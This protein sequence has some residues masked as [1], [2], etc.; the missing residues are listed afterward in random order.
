MLVM[1]DL[2]G[3]D[4]FVISV[5]LVRLEK[6]YELDQ[7]G[8]EVRLIKFGNLGQFGQIREAIEL[9]NVTKS[10]KSAQLS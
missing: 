8:F 6:L 7:V 3:Q 4:S 1:L 2:Y 5:R 10:G 9:K